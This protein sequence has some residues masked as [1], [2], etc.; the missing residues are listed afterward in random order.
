MSWFSLK[1]VFFEDSRIGVTKCSV[2]NC[3]SCWG[4]S[5]SLRLT[6]LS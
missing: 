4:V 2:I 1:A 6:S 5:R 3:F